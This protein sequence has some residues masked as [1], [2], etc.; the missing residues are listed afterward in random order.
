[1]SSNGNGK[2][3]TGN[4]RSTIVTRYLDQKVWRVYTEDPVLIRRLERYGFVA[5]QIRPYAKKF[6]IP[7]ASILF[8][9]GKKV[10]TR[11]EYTEEEKTAMRE[12]L[13]KARQGSR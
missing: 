1:M 3:P 6:E 2:G 12:R 9:K 10:S 13:A 5:V 4:E 11:R 7:L 8:R